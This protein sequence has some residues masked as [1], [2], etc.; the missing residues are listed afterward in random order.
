MTIQRIQFKYLDWKIDLAINKD[1]KEATNEGRDLP[2]GKKTPGI[3]IFLPAHTFFL[4]I[5]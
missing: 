3:G 2:N 4:S 1:E 5:N